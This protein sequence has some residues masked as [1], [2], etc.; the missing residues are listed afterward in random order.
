[1]PVPN[2]TSPHRSSLRQPSRLPHLLPIA[3]LLLIL[4]CSTT[5]FARGP[6]PA[7]TIPLDPLGYQPLS[8]RYLLDGSSMI[9][10]D[11]V[12][13]THLLLT[14]NARRLIRRIPG[15]PPT[16]QDR[17]VDALLLELPSGRVL[18][19]AEWVL[20]DH[21]HY[22]WNLGHG[23]FLFRI[24]DNFNLIAPLANLKRGN[25]FAE[26]PFLRSNRQ[27]DV[28]T[29]SADASFLTIETTEPQPPP[30]EETQSPF[31]PLP[32]PSRQPSDVQL[33]FYRLRQSATE[34]DGYILPQ[35][36]GMARAN[37]FVEL[38][39]TPGGILQILDEG[40]QRWAFDFRAHTGKLS[41]LALFDSTCR[42]I[43]MFISPSEFVAFG[44]R[45]GT[46]RQQLAAFNLRG[47]ATW[48]AAL[49]GPFIAPYL[50]FAPSAGRFALGRVLTSSA[51]FP[52][53]SVDPGFFNG[54]SVDVFQDDSGKQLLHIDC[55]PIARAGQNFAL[56][57]DGMNLAV[58][59]E[60][61]V[62]IFPLPP[63]GP[64]DKNA[65][66]LAQD[67]TPPPTDAMIDLST[68][69]PNSSASATRSSTALPSNSA[70]SLQLPDR[71]Q[72]QQINQPDAQSTPSSSPPSSS[73]TSTSTLA[74]Q[75]TAPSSASF[76]SASTPSN[77][78]APA[79]PPVH[80][81]PPTLY[82]P[83]AP[84]PDAP[85]QTQP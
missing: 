26:R 12:D 15:D 52:S 76:P 49:N 70:D 69:S 31:S 14:Y 17:N 77:D 81:K 59:R 84:S 43:P 46:T 73:P 22:L 61:A 25:A 40:H 11:Y 44:C 24:R 53:D 39:L 75:P 23:Q 71:S 74:P 41:Q 66:K 85:P 54:Q 67:S 72:T 18:A 48:E 5:L 58:I 2:H 57:P 13:D 4:A 34:N 68:P 80:R 78:S 63:L 21:G 64:Q 45:G 47:D 82:N 27:V 6:Q 36:A 50:A 16:D 60:D 65:I 56:S 3:S 32:Q 30:P 10:L 37:R 33:N 8:L 79:D 29:L 20:H 51:G 42:P 9:T 38:P 35:V 28:V 19:R 83:P 7:V 55:A 62:E 1:M